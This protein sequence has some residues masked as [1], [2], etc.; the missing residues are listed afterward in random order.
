MI[1]DHHRQHTTE[2]TSPHQDA[3]GHT[4]T[5]VDF[6]DMGLVELPIILTV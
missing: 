4:R 3:Q 2:L 1:T 5:M 6:Q